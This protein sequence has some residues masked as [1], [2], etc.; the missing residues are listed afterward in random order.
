MTQSAR[1]RQM[2]LDELEW[3]SREGDVSRRIKGATLGMISLALLLAVGM[4][5]RTCSRNFADASCGPEKQTIVRSA[6]GKHEAVLSNQYCAPGVGAS[7]NAY[8][9]TVRSG[10][11]L[12]DKGVRVFETW[13]FAPDPIWRDNQNLEVKIR[14]VSDIGTSLHEAGVIKISY[15]IDEKLSEENFRKKMDK[16]Q[17]KWADEFQ[18]NPSSPQKK[19]VKAAIVSAWADYRRFKEWAEANAERGN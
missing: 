13:N 2:P 15:W 7:S 12:S 10:S 17:Q 9:I 3:R 5:A 14:F 19:I 4:T 8:W 18:T 11:G 1:H 16:Y 6:D